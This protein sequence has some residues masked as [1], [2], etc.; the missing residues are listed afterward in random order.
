LAALLAALRPLCQGDDPTVRLD[1]I[2]G[3]SAGSITGL[4]AARCLLEGI[5]P[6]YVM[7]EA[8]VV[9]ASLERLREDGTAAPV[10][11]E[12]LR[13]DAADLLDPRDATG[14][15]A[16]RVD[17]RQSRPVQLVTA[18]ACLRGLE[19]RVP[20]LSVRS[21]VQASTHLDWE[22]FTVES[23]ASLRSLLE[24][25]DVSPV[26]VALASAANPFGFPPRLLDRRRDE[27]FYRDRGIRNFPRSGQLWYTDG[28]M[29][30][31]EPLTRTLE[32]VR[33]L[34]RDLG[35]DARRVQLL[36][37][38]HPTGATRGKAWADPGNPPTWLASLR[39]ARDLQR[40]QTVY[41]D[42]VHLAE[43][44]T[45]IEWARRLFDE[46]EPVLTGLDDD[47]AARL[48]EAVGRALT[49]IEGQRRALRAR[50]PDPARATEAIDTERP[51][52]ELLRQA[53]D[54]IAGIAG[55]EPIAL[56]VVSPLV[57]PEAEETPVSRML[58]GEFF[59]HFG[60]FLDEE[61]RQS[62]FDLGYRSTLEWL[63]GG[64]LRAHGLAAELDAAALETA[65][66]AYR[67]GTSWEM[68]GR[69][70]FRSLDTDAKLDLVRLFAHAVRVLVHDLRHPRPQ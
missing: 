11:I 45:R 51:P 41:D 40:T 18:L 19:Y 48:R 59:L 43:T 61:L 4:L 44:N 50:E 55:K 30:D 57:L 49:V 56:E 39:R 21:S 5:D 37:H 1:A 46:M 22:T 54:R 12:L 62:D 68:L 64:G 13:A 16:R 33:E 52:V 28:G 58:A 27:H 23:G 67:P 38:P 3:S 2:G 9:R 14:A 8:W 10:S 60:G 15:P 34:D 20:S 53:V 25:R 69:H 42:L 32:L 26:D 17:R 63:R 36:V 47:Q 65:E 31:S 24:P 6:V 35:S 29:L 70:S 66:D 7:R